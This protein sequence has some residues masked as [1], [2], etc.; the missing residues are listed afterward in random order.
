MPYTMQSRLN[1]ETSSWISWWRV[2]AILY[3]LSGFTSLAYEVLW[4]RMLSMQFGVSIFGVVLTVAAFMIGLG[5]GSLAGVRWAKRSKMPLVL[6]AVLELAISLYALILPSMLHSVSGWMESIAIR[7]TLTQ[8]YLLQGA[9]ALCLL[10]IPAFAMGI[11]FALVLKAVKH[12]PLSLG[13]LYGLNTI[14]GAAGALF[15]L[16]S[17]PVLGWILSVRIT[18]L[19]GLAVGGAALALSYFIQSNVGAHQSTE[20]N[21]QH[22][23]PL[24]ALIIYAGIGAGSIMLE[25]G[26]IRLY[27][28]VML[29]TEYVLGVI[30]AVFLL[31]IALGSMALPRVHKYWLNVLMPLVIGAGVLINLWLL[32]VASA[33]VEHSQFQSFF[34]ALGSQAL[35]LGILTLPVTLALGAWLPL[36]A[37]R[38]G[39]ADASGVW[40]Y[41]AN[42][43]GGAAGAIVACLVLIPSFGSTA[44]VVI[45]GLA[46]AALGLIW[47]KSH[48][49]WLAFAVMLLVAWPLRNMPP[50]HELLP[51]ADADSRDLYLYEDAISLTHVIQQQDGQRVLLSDLQRMDASTDP[52]AV[53]IQMDQARLALLLHPAP[54][55]ALF[56]GLGT[57]ISMAGSLPFPGV[58]RVAVELSQGSI[59][60]ARKWFAPANG[61]IM[62]HARVQR[63]DARHFLSTTRRNYDVIVGDLFHPDLAGMGSLLS[64]QQFQRARTHLNADGIFVQWLALNQFDIQSLDVVMR[65]FRRVFPDAQMFMDGMHLALVGSMGKLPMAGVMQANLHRLSKQEQGRATGDEG[66]WTWLGR[67][68]GPISESDGPVQDEWVPYVEYN[69]PRARY[70]GSVNLAKLMSWLLQRHPGAD[71]AMKILGIRADDRNKFGRAYVA[72]ELAVRAWISSIQG[73]EVKAGSL[74]WLAYQA[75]P[76]DHWI[77]NELA[78]NM[79]QSLPQASQHGLSKREA[80][81]RILKVYPNFVGALR[82]LWHL[83]QTD[84]NLQEAE[85][86]RLR[87][88]AI[89]PLDGEAVATP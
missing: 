58:D 49:A 72:T 28:M 85:R 71:A 2:V 37:G 9:E 61:N 45:A 41:G 12:T 42:C 82:A 6:F 39:S 21:K 35:M 38:F 83:E 18:A 76:Q 23:P 59:F 87:L 88:L 66:M 19:I 55:S 80:L 11:S 81:Q 51:K 7:L 89:S 20:N 30:L 73:D 15:P 5:L 67:Y 60:A 70:D 78:D 24:P 31:G 50:A 46:I 36:L 75:N 54:H 16:W 74:I 77:A 56:L 17:L 27:G 68:W 26:W 53:E 43:L 14:G 63:D 69:L 40:L 64:V 34:G 29:R 65:S 57:G 1:S 79:L 33:W 84:G 52:S 86:Y 44:M 8:W 22:S 62:D 4:A 13:K 48:R 32:P 10:V 25:I 47:V 3:F